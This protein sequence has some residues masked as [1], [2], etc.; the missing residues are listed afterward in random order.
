[1]EI[2]KAKV[3][4]LGESNTGKTSLLKRLAFNCFDEN[5]FESITSAVYTYNIEYHGYELQFEIWDTSGVS[6]YRG[7]NRNFYHN[8]DVIVFVYSIN[9]IKSFREIKDYWYKEIKEHFSKKP[10]KIFF[11]WVIVLAIVANKSDLFFQEEITEE[12]GRA[13]AKEINA[14]FCMT[15]SRN[16]Q[17]ITEL[18]QMI[19]EKYFEGDPYSNDCFVNDKKNV[20]IIHKISLNSKKK[21][22]KIEKTN[23]NNFCLK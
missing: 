5:E 11:L 2:Q 22:K 1:M 23:Q 7:L 13:F 16:N 12:V 15:S 10:S 21:I 20:K 19:G 18:F 14:L 9:N 4:L 17:N 8:V 3:V 6:R